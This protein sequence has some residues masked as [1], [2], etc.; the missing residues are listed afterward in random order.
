M[1][2]RAANTTVP[3]YDDIYQCV[4]DLKDSEKD[5]LYTD[6][7][8]CMA[9]Y[10]ALP[11][12]PQQLVL[13]MLLPNCPLSTLFPKPETL[14]AASSA[15]KQPP[16]VEWKKMWR[17]ADNKS[18]FDFVCKL[19]VWVLNDES[20]DR[21]RGVS[22]TP[23]DVRL[24]PVYRTNLLEAL[25]GDGEVPP[26]QKLAMHARPTDAMVKFGW[27][28]WEKVL[29]YIV[30]SPKLNEQPN[31]TMINLLDAAWLVKLR[32]EDQ[33]PQLT[34]EGFQFLLRDTYSQIWRVLQQYMHQESIA[35]HKLDV[36]KLLFR[37]GFSKVAVPYALRNLTEVQQTTVLDL[38]SFGLTHG[39]P[40]GE[41]T[42]K[43]FLITPL[44][45]H[46]T[47]PSRD[48]PMFKPSG[49]GSKDDGT[50]YIIV[51]TN[52]HVYA[53]T[54]NT[55]QIELLSR[56]VEKRYELPGLY[57]G[58]ITRNSILGALKD[59]ITANEILGY[60]FHRAHPE[61]HKT[62]K[63]VLP[64]TVVDQIRLW[65]SERNRIKTK[66]GTLFSNFSS[67]DDY[68][69]KKDIVKELGD[70]FII[71]ENEET[72]VF[73]VPSDKVEEAVDALK[74]AAKRVR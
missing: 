47:S 12:L 40:K 38:E 68:F 31:Q 51:E 34:P 59:G 27:N 70:D 6:V 54:T 67:A 20:N 58:L 57:V 53:Y 7:W 10:R 5:D 43:N 9:I 22:G 44:G 35:P 62:N 65:E 24:H 8:S 2:R 3:L 42:K 69:T 63:F 64:E 61:M 18:N 29:K 52:Y 45:V 66:P 50:G 55:L 19:R 23:V 13:R 26:K 56:F 1:S 17:S 16:E 15:N 73:V 21:I 11:P 71:F 60:L 32:E 28:K 41:V 36:I 74:K 49:A 25:S 30:R 14:P 4:A 46:L 37:M 33:A 48:K 39:L 72:Q